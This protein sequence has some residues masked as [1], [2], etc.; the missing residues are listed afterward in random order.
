MPADYSRHCPW[1]RKRVSNPIARKSAISQG[2]LSEMTPAIQR[3]DST[4]LNAVRQAGR[5]STVRTHRGSNKPVHALRH[6]RG[7]KH[8]LQ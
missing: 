2:A 8:G 5:F 3:S 1:R 7:C 4:D 6:K